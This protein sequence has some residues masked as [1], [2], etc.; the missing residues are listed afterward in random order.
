MDARKKSVADADKQ[1]A[2]RDDGKPEADPRLMVEVEKMPGELSE[3]K[4][5]RSAAKDS[6]D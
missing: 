5:R 3:R 1:P 4:Q 2:S 6:G